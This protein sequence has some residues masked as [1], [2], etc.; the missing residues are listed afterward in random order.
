MKVVV[1]IACDA[2][3]HY[4]AWCP[5]LPG[6]VACAPSLKEVTD[7]IDQAIRGYLASLNGAPPAEVR[8]VFYVG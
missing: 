4:R 1:K 2:D 3:Q 5:A 8:T 7:R 6:C